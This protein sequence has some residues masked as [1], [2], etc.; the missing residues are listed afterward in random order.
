MAAY[1][2]GSGTI[3]RAIKKNQAQQAPYDYWSL[4][5]P[6]ET[7]QYVPKLLAIAEI[8]NRP[9][10]FA[11]TLPTLPNRPT[12]SIIH[13]D[14]QMILR[15]AAQL[16]KV[17][18]KTLRKLNAGYKQGVTPPEGP[19]RLLIPIDHTHHFTQGLADYRFEDQQAWSRY[20]VALGDNLTLIARRFGA[21]IHDIR[22]LNRIKKDR[23][24]E[25]QILLIP[26]NL[27]IA[28]RTN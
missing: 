7:E 11:I 9:E 28:N 5:L 17:D 6:R 15:D 3:S 2:A 23:I 1:N 18:L 10:R 12:F 19:H 22:A 21:T 14:G 20:R 4:S 13:N 24:Y 16:A 25:N 26:K 8:I 27:T